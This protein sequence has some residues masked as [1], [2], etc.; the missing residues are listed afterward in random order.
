M[1]VFCVEEQRCV[2]NGNCKVCL[3]E[4]RSSLLQRSSVRKHS[5]SRK[6]RNEGGCIHTFPHNSS[7]CLPEAID[8]RP[9]KSQRTQ[10]WLDERPQ[11]QPMRSTLSDRLTALA[12]LAWW[13]SSFAFVQNSVHTKQIL[14]IASTS[15]SSLCHSVS[16]HRSRVQQHFLS[17]Y[18]YFL[19]AILVLSCCPLMSRGEMDHSRLSRFSSTPPPPSSFPPSVYNNVTGNHLYSK[20]RITD[21]TSIELTETTAAATLLANVVNSSRQKQKAERLPHTFDIESDVASRSANFTSNSN[22]D[23][24]HRHN[25]RV[26]QEQYLNM[27]DSPANLFDDLLDS[28]RGSHSLPANP[29]YSNEFAIHIPAGAEMAD[30]VAAKHGFTNMGQV[31][32]LKLVN[33]YCV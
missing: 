8:S 31:S 26:L 12:W 19:A 21:N 3:V 11:R 20:E 5:T 16:I 15:I 17:L 32:S 29:I 25:N 9:V 33:I 30:L 4:G 6:Q 18:A 22:S 27:I 14:P 13:W 1:Y 7:K 2:V 24:S 28:F 10:Q 23:D